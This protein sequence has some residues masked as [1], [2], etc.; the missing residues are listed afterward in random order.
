MSFSLGDD[1]II[2][3]MKKS[4]LPMPI[5][6]GTWAEKSKLIDSEKLY[7]HNS[8]KKY[9]DI[10]KRGKIPLFISTMNLCHR[11]RYID[12]NDMIKQLNITFPYDE[13]C[14]IYYQIYYQK[15][16]QKDLQYNYISYCYC[17]M[18]GY[19]HF[20]RKTGHAFVIKRD[21]YIDNNNVSNMVLVDPV[22]EPLEENI[23][24]MEYWGNVYSLEDIDPNHIMS[25]K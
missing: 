15:C 12:I 7:S 18:I 2:K 8:L 14:K 6:N 22:K 5:M 19:L 9:L 10:M 25:V 3:K 23:K 4:G 1:I 20:I 13:I 11:F 21:L 24:D 16:Y 17:T